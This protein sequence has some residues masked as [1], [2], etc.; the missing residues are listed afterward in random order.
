MSHQNLDQE[1]QAPHA[2]D[3]PTAEGPHSVSAQSA[4]TASHTPG[5]WMVDGFLTTII[6]TEGHPYKNGPMRIADVRGWGHLTGAGACRFPEEK[7]VAIQEANARLIAAAPELLTALQAVIASGCP[8]AKE[9]PI[10]K[11]AWER[12]EAAIAKAV[13][14]EAKRAGMD[15]VSFAPSAPETSTK[16]ASR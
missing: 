15:D 4:V 12:G 16:K 1:D 6:W 9:H 14:S 10:M 7:A 11:A 13:G 5:P 8:N 2:P 3:R